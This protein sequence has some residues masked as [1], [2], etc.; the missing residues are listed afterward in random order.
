[1]TTDDRSEEGQRIRGSIR[2]GVSGAGEE[3]IVGG[4]GNS[5]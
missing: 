5:R 3:V 2:A 1:V 4:A